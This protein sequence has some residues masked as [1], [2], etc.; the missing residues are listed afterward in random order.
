M[1]VGSAL[2]VFLLVADW[3]LPE[4]PPSFPDRA[5]IDKAT[6]RI[7]SEHKWPE[8]IVLDTSNP[9]MTALVV[10]DPPVTQSSV[11][12]PPDRAPGQASLDSMGQLESDPQPVA[13]DLPTLQSR[14]GVART[15]RSRHVARS[16]ITHRLAGAETGRGCCQFRWIDSHQTKSHGVS[17]RQAASSWPAEW[18]MLAGRN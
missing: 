4:S 8:K 1:V 17:R 12:L 3:F 13:I 15:A 6:I 10:A 9:T 2:L 5:D 7:R 14:R 11:P 16:S 18:P